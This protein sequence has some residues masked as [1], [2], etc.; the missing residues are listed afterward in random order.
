MLDGWL[1][2]HGLEDG[3]HM[4]SATAMMD[5]AVVP[6]IPAGFFISARCAAAAAACARQMACL[7]GR[8]AVLWRDLWETGGSGKPTAGPRV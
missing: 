2:G 4:F 1:Y 8:Q 5:V 7:A 3:V 6:V